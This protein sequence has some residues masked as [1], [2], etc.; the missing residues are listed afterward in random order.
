M[1]FFYRTNN[2]LMIYVFDDLSSFEYVEIMALILLQIGIW[3]W[4]VI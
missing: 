2:M 3:V 4:S 1:C